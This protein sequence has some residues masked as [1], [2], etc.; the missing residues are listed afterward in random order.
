[1]AA[2]LFVRQASPEDAANNDG[3]TRAGTLGV[4]QALRFS[5]LIARSGTA[6][7]RRLENGPVMTVPGKPLPRFALADDLAL[8]LI[9]PP[10]AKLAAFYR[11]WDDQVRHLYGEPV[12]AA[13]EKPVPTLEN[14][15]RL[16]L[17]QDIADRT[18]PNGASI[19]FVLEAG[20]KRMLFA[21]DAH[22]DD[23]AAGIA[24]YAGDGRV[25]FDAIKVSH[26]GSARNNTS[27]LIDR[28]QSP[29]WLISTDG[30]RHGHP[31]PE[32]MARIVLAS[33]KAK[34]L[35]FNYHSAANA[36]WDGEDLKRV[37]GYRT[38]YGDGVTAT[39]VEI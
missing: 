6:W 21:A 12:L 9:G 24:L 7:N 17:E 10:K 29:Y 36:P 16:A 2:G 26:H 1:M 33:E 38:C 25:C 15:R 18:K 11:E 14:L 37:F 39:T 34:T 13:R 23:L 27:P 30:S 20:A 5:A 8:V 19:A 32:A 3:L 4:G 28:L 35:V 31:D 22:P